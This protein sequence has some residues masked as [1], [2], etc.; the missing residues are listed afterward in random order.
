MKKLILALIILLN[1]NF[2]SCA[3]I[4]N[5]TIVRVYARKPISTENYQVGDFVYFVNPT[6]MWQGREIIIPEGTVFVGNVATLHMPVQG[7]NASMSIKVDQM[8]TPTGDSYDI[9]ATLTYKGKETIGGEQ[10]SPASY[11][12]SIHYIAP[13]RGVMQWVPSGEWL[14]GKHI[15]ITQKNELYITFTNNLIL[16]D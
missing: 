16:K 9:S 15:T 8:I 2:A 1:I 3:E 5:G 11:N 10:T 4:M 6:D 14:E 12:R 13:W 7:V